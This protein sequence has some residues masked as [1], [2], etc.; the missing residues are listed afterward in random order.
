MAVFCLH[1]RVYETPI[2]FNGS[3]EHIRAEFLP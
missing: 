2:V 1:M 3:H